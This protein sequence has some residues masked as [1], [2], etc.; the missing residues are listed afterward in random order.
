MV[1]VMETAER[2]FATNSSGQRAAL[3]SCVNSEREGGERHLRIVGAFDALSVGEI[4]PVFEAAVADPPGRV[5]VDLE[6]VPVIDSSGVV[7]LVSLWRRMTAKGGSLVVVGA[8]D[9]P[10][11]VLRLLKLDAVFGIT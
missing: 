9:Q 5:V 2:Y 7:A 10:L 11:A 1:A 3:R 6:E 8:R 4:R